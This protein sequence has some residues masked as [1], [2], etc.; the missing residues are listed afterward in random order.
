MPASGYEAHPNFP[1]AV[2]ALV[3]LPAAAQ[4]GPAG[5]LQAITVDR[6]DPSVVYTSGA[7]TMWRSADYGNTW[8]ASQSSVNAWSIA[9]DNSDLAGNRTR[10]RSSTRRPRTMV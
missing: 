7:G 3:V 4:E 6:N 2:L 1:A 10:Y 8:S 9:I 5:I